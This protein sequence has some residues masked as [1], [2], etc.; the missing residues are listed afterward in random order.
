ML[1]ALTVL[2]FGFGLGL[3]L[4]APPGPIM[5]LSA[6]RLVHRGYLAGFLVILG[7]IVADATHL[8]LVALG[9]IPLVT[10]VPGLLALLTLAGALLLLYFA[11]GAWRTARRPP[12]G[13]DLAEAPPPKSRLLRFIRGGFATGYVL[14]ITSPFNIAWWLSVGGPLMSNHGWVLFLGFFAALFGYSLFFLAVVQWA[15]GRVKGIVT[16]V[17]YTSAVLLALFALRLIYTGVTDVWE[18]WTG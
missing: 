16:V 18:V 3:T 14:A 12:A 2:A 13:R 15:S 4:A 7:A 1:D 8:L 9:V 17:S 10:R 6:E 11:Y 5:A